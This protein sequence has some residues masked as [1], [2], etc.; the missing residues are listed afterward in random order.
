MAW[1]VD[2][3]FQQRIFTE[4]LVVENESVT[5]IHR[6]LKIVYGITVVEKAVLNIR[7]HKFYASENLQFINSDRKTRRH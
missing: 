5:H 1:Q 3:R 6:R 4:F 7:I 2:L